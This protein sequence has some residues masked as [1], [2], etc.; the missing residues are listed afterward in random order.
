M[1]SKEH[2][3]DNDSLDNLQDFLDSQSG[4]QVKCSY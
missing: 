3:L 4:R 2:S 1:Y